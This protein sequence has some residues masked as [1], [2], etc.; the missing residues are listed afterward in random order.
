MVVCSVTEEFDPDPDRSSPSSSE[1]SEGEVLVAERTGDVRDDGVNGGMAP[2]ILPAAKTQPPTA[3]L[4]NES[5]ARLPIMKTF[6]ATSREISALGRRVRPDMIIGLAKGG[7]GDV[8][9][10]V[11]LL[12]TCARREGLR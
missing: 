5:P 7:S 10:A 2:S 12:R 6:L 9:V 3:C 8:V 11:L 1:T 4:I